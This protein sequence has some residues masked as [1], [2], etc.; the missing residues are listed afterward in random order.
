M[1]WV[2]LYVVMQE[3]QNIRE[4][5]PIGWADSFGSRASC[6][7]KVG[8]AIKS[9]ALPFEKTNPDGGREGMANDS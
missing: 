6:C 5:F 3:S 7:H 1:R 2:T 9:A 8:L 4:S